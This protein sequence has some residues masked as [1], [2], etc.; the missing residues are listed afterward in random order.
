VDPSL[1]RKWETMYFAKAL[2]G[3]PDMTYDA[4]IETIKRYA[5]SRFKSILEHAA[6]DLAVDSYLA[7][8]YCQMRGT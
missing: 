8:E 4:K 3:K 1:E 5:L 2:V 6:R 7:A